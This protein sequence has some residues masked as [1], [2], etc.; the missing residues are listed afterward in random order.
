MSPKI[1]SRCFARLS[2]LR[3]RHA[4][5]P[6]VAGG[7]ALTLI[8]TVGVASAATIQAMQQQSHDDR[9]GILLPTGARITPTATPGARFERMNPNL[10]SLPGFQAGQA[11]TTALSP[12][13]NTLLVL[14]SGYNR[15]WNPQGKIDP[16]TSSEYIFIYDLRSGAPV[17]RQVLEVPDTFSGIAWQPDGRQFF[18]AGGVDDNV[19]RYGL[20]VSQWQEIQPA[21]PLGH[22]NKGLGI[23]VRPMAAGLA[24]SPDGKRLLVANFENDS[25]SE[26][27]LALGKVVHELDLRPGKIN[28]A[29]AGVP[30]GEFPFW[31]AYQGADKA[32]VTSMRD[33][34]V[35]VLRIRNG[36]L[37]VIKRI[38]VGG[39]PTRMVLNRAKTRLYVANSNSDTVTVID[40][41]HDLVLD[42]IGTTAPEKTYAN[43]SQLKG[44]NPNSLALSPD[45]KT[46]YVTNGGTNA[47]AVMHL[48]DRKGSS[49]VRGLIP[50]GWYPNSVSVSHDGKTLYIVNGKSMAGPNGGNCRNSVSTDKAATLSCRANNKY[51]WQLTKAGF[52]TVPVPNTPEL[53]KLTRQVAINNNWADVRDKAEAEKLMAF[54]RSHIKH[55]IYVVKENRTYDQV[56]G[57]LRPG[58]GDASLVLLPE[59]ITP[60]HHALARQFVTLDNFLVSGA[61]SNDGWIWSTAARSSEY[62]EKNIAINYAGRGLSYDN[63]GQNRNINLGLASP[64]ERHAEDPHAPDDPDLMPGVGDVAAPDGPGGEVGAGY[65][66]DAALRAGITIRNYGFYQDED[67]YGLPHDDP[68]YVPPSRHPF[69]DKMIQAYSNKSALRPIT[70]PYFRGF[71]QNYADF[72]RY[73][74]WEREFDDYVKSGSLPAL[75]LVRLPHDHFGDFA[76]AADGVNTVE[77]QMADNDY[78]LGL[79][80]EKISNSPFRD[81]TLIVVVEDDAQDGGDHVDAHRSL[82]YMIGPYV[83]RHAVVSTRY[84]TVNLLRTIEDVLGL[85]PMGLTDGN[86][87]PMTAVFDR[88]SQP[89]DYTAIVPEVLR[90]TQLP[91]PPKTVENSLAATPGAEQYAKPR[92]HAA[93][94]A[95]VMQGQNFATE[96][97]L[98]TVRFNKALWQGLKGV[99]YSVH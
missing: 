73:K 5:V 31:V 2:G 96:D 72:W 65:L 9:A 4:L 6:M 16:A 1:M 40:A 78:A 67:R 11:V 93:Y 58:N 49:S 80:A 69:A 61:A 42:T 27:D 12:D 26:I 62:T 81:N 84:T 92:H 91:L 99:D 50:T 19:H 59:P 48:D 34:E 57:D 87:L 94:W 15:N 83:K 22:D 55:V 98:D 17:K 28:P 3:L 29:R 97:Q 88:H 13:G 44:S 45:E 54:I 30:G 14:T 63:E 7:I 64:A 32:Y 35:V 18:V 66:W 51:I 79:L 71:D 77:T 56:L 60:N 36:A 25:V 85:K 76:T 95:R 46:L 53:A 8:G 10:P 38:P 47:V 37:S 68:A 82:A 90:T 39:Q 43:A 21:I 74:E 86:A 70:D 23:K 75:E 24:V 33:R 52:L 89:L 41:K 20:K